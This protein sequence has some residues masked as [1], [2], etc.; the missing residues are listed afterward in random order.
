MISILYIVV[1]TCVKLAGGKCAI[2]SHMGQL[3]SESIGERVREAREAEGLSRR[4]LSE[5]AGLSSPVAQHIETGTNVPG[6]DTVEKLAR[7]LRVSPSWLAYGGSPVRRVLNYL[8][9]P[10]FDPLKLAQDYE[11]TLGG[12]GGRLPPSMLYLD[13]FGAAQYAELAKTY[14][15]LPLRQAALMIAS[16]SH[17]ALSVIALGSGCA[18]HETRLVEHLVESKANFDDSEPLE[19]YLIDVSQPLLSV[20]YRHAAGALARSNVSVVAIEG[21]FDKLPKF[22]NFFA[23]RGPRRNLIT[24]LGYT[25]GNFSNEIAFVRDTLVGCSKGDMLLFDYLVSRAAP[26]DPAEIRK[27]DPIANAERPG[28]ARSAHLS[29]LLNPITRFYGKAARIEVSTN[30]VAGTCTV[31]NSYA[32]ELV[33]TVDTPDGPKSF[34]TASWKRYDPEE[35]AKALQ[36]IGWEEV[37]SWEFDDDRPSKLAL[38]RRV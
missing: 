14:K 3:R 33:A 20:G 29:F 18:N 36:R 27:A 7:V 11:E 38:F 16:L 1:E 6:I 31:P 25:I 13:P 10:G 35:F 30:V 34:I 8:S 17:E 5:L 23:P 19:L 12:C 22:M 2:R 24:M 32:V 4:K 26:D 9:A 37:K 15:G 28:T 21:D